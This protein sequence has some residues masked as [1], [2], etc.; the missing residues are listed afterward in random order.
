MGS[1]LYAY[2]T[3]EGDRLESQE[4]QELAEDSGAGEV[5]GAGG[6]GQVVARLDA[7]S[8]ARRGEESELWVDTTKLHFFDAETGKNLSRASFRR[9]DR[10]QRSFGRSSVR[11]VLAPLVRAHQPV[12]LGH[13]AHVDVGLV[14]CRR[15]ARLAQHVRPPVGSPRG[16]RPPRPP[17]GS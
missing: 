2:F 12:A 9:G 8:K 15:A 4:L 10:G 13:D 5:P 17:R 6:E 16:T 11:I 14:A 3:V 1:E 7:A